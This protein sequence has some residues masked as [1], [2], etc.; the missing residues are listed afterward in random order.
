MSVSASWR[1]ERF[2]ARWMRSSG[3]RCRF[4]PV[5][6]R[7]GL[8]EHPL[9][10]RDDQAGALGRLEELAGQEQPALGMVPAHERLDPDGAAGRD[11]DDRLVVQDEL[12]TPERV[13][14]LVLHAHPDASGAAHRV[15][16]HLD[17]ARGAVRLG[18]VHRRVGL[19]EQRFGRGD[20][21]GDA[22]PRRC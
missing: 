4:Q 15:V 11:L 2:T 9:A 8:R 16:E 21:V 6:G 10:D 22:A 17:L 5:D 14:E 3:G 18:E 12:V 1:G 19:A 20:L 7:A 13:R